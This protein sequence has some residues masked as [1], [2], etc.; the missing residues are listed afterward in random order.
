MERAHG[1]N[2]HIARWRPSA[3][4]RGHTS[5]AAEIKMKSRVL[6]VA[7]ALALGSSTF[8]AAPAFAQSDEA[9]EIAQLKQQLAALQAKVNELEQRSDAQ[10]SINA[11]TQ[12]NLEA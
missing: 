9:A 3:P 11:S 6:A 5:T 8:V 2:R 7:V 1:C 10:S 12:Q 4:D